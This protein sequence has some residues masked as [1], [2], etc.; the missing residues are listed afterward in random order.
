MKK[1]IAVLVLLLP[2]V[3]HAQIAKQF[4]HGYKNVNGYRFGWMDGSDTLGYFRSVGLQ[5]KKPILLNT[6]NTAGRPSSPVAGMVGFNSDSATIEWYSTSSWATPVKTE[7]ILLKGS[8]TW[9]PGTVA[10]G[11]STTTTISV[12]GAALGDP[13]TVS[14]ASGAYSN[15]EVYD[16]FV[17]AT[18]TVTIRVHNVSTGSANYNTSETY[19]V[20]LFKF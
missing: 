16:A 12:T 8:T 19:K 10:A 17:S 7:A 20:I 2:V 14:K 11:S 9:T 1:L 6:W 3:C 5:M 4:G 18:N 15:G 13:A